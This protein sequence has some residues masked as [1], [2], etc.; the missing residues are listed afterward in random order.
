M[1]PIMIAHDVS[2]QRGS[3]WITYVECIV[4]TS[5]ALEPRL[6]VLGLGALVFGSDDVP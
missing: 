3:I 2:M 6:L 5:V 1:F 4:V